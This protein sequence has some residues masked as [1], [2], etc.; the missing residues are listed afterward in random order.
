MRFVCSRG[1]ATPAHA[2]TVASDLSSDLSSVVLAK[3]E[4]LAKEEGVAGSLR[5]FDRGFHGWRG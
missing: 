4:A 3:E 2:G 1:P 5:V